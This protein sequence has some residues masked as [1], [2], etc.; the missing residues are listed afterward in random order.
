LG[1]GENLSAGGEKRLGVGE[2]LSAGGEGRLGGGENLSAGG[3]KRLG[4]GEKRKSMPSTK[5][6]MVAIS[7]LKPVGAQG[8]RP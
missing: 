8:L 2:S 1:V 3:E 6:A 7:L 5:S 4:G